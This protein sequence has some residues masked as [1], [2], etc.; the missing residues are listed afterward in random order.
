VGPGRLRERLAT[1]LV[2]DIY[3]ILKVAGEAPAY[4]L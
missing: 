4:A 2:N 1:G 3:L